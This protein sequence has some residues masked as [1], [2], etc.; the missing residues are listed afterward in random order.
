[1]CPTPGDV[2]PVT[3][4]IVIHCIDQELLHLAS[5]L[6]HPFSEQINVVYNFTFPS[7]CATVHGR[8]SDE[9]RVEALD[10]SSPFSGPDT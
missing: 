8:R 7:R 5:A 10:D 4:G 1:M 3:A 6:Q 9:C 2:F